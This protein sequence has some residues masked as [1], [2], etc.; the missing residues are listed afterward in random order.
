MMKKNNQKVTMMSW[1][2][3]RHEP[4]PYMDAERH[5]A[6]EDEESY[7][8]P[9]CYQ[10]GQPI[11]DKYG[12]L[13]DDKW[14]CRDCLGDMYEAADEPCTVCGDNYGEGYRVSDDDY[15]CDECMKHEFREDIDRYE[16]YN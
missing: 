11:E 5:Y 9:I 10:C 7:K 14:L 8:R 3:T 13:I 12:Y 4:E 6:S 2:D 1:I 16:N 15:I